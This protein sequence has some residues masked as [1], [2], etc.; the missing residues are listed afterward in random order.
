VSSEA[1]R[2]AIEP[3]SDQLNA[4]DLTGGDIVVTVKSVKVSE[5]EQPVQISLV[6]TPKFY[7]P[8]KSMSR[9]MVRLWGPDPDTYAGRKMRLYCDPEVKWGGMKVG[10]IRISEVSSLSEAITFPLTEKRGLKKMVTIRP[11]TEEKLSPAV[12]FGRASAR[13][14][15]LN[16]KKAFTDW[17]NSAEGKD[18]RATGDDIIAELQRTVTQVEEANGPSALEQRLRA[19]SENPASPSEGAPRPS[20]VEEE[21][22]PA[23][24]DRGASPAGDT[25]AF[26]EEQVFPGSKAFTE[27]EVARLQGLDEGSNPYRENPEFS[28]WL[29]GYRARARG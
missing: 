13:A 24:E 25:A 3:K 28:E 2:K 15:A 4:D 5:G 26:D 19:A 9:V 23:G 21:Q 12:E 29:G 22:G 1:F 7:R 27:G 6:E 14:A 20:D 11:L 10:G 17:W 8:C 18:Y 16:G